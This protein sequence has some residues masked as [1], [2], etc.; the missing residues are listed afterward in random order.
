MTKNKN[1]WGNHEIPGF[2]NEYI[3]SKDFI[4]KS[5]YEELGQLT[6]MKWGLATEEEKQELKN[7]QIQSRDYNTWYE[8]NKKKNSSDEMSK[9]LSEAQLKRY[10]DPDK[11]KKHQEGINRFFSDPENRRLDSE[12]KSQRSK[13]KTYPKE[14]GEK[15]SQSKNKRIHVPW[16]IFGSRKEATK[17]AIDNNIP[18]PARKI[19]RGL[20]DNPEDYYYI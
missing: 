3:F 14:F 6:K 4:K 8:K 11:K 16:G 9:K 18:D 15:I 2:D 12:R 19:G 13:G 20:K 7:K 5:R 1:N 17:Y 10:S